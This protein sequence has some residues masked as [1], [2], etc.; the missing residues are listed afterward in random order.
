MNTPYEKL[1]EELIHT[2]QRT[3]DAFEI[4][5]LGDEYEA[6]RLLAEIRGDIQK[7]FKMLKAWDMV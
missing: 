3:I 2:L 6:K 5:A 7:A 4:E 1:R